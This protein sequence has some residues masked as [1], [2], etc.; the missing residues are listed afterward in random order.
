MLY[1]GID[2]NEFIAEQ[3]APEKRN[4]SPRNLVSDTRRGQWVSEYSGMKRYDSGS[5]VAASYHAIEYYA[6][7]RLYINDQNIFTHYTPECE[8][9]SVS[10]KELKL[11]IKNS[12]AGTNYANKVDDIYNAANKTQTGVINILAKLR[13]EQG[14]GT[15]LTQGI[16]DGNK[17]YYNPYNIC[18]SGNSTKAIIANALAKAKKENWDTFE[19]ALIGGIKLMQTNYTDQNT[20]YLEKFNAT[21][22]NIKSGAGNQYMQNIEDPYSQGIIKR[23]TFLEIDKNLSGRYVFKIPVFKNMPKPRIP[24]P[25]SN[26]TTPNTSGIIKTKPSLPRKA[27]VSIPEGLN[28]R[29]AP[30]LRNN[31]VI[32]TIAP[33]EMIDVIS[34]VKDQGILSWYKIRYNG[35]VGYTTRR[36]E[37][38]PDYFVFMVS[39]VE[40]IKKDLVEKED[41]TKTTYPVTVVFQDDIRIRSAASLSGMHIKWADRGTSGEILGFA[42]S[43]DGYDWYKI[44]NGKSFGYIA[45]NETGSKDFWFLFYEDHMIN[46]NEQQKPEEPEEPEPS[47]E[48]PI[49]T[50][51]IKLIESRMMYG[52]DE[53]I[54]I[55]IDQRVDDLRKINPGVDIKVLDQSEKETNRFMTGGKIKYKDKTHNIVVRGDMN[56]DGQISFLDVLTISSHLNGKITLKNNK[57]TAAFLNL[58]YTNEKVEKEKIGIGVNQMLLLISYMNGYIKYKLD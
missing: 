8:I 16:K 54:Y 12:I 13:Q 56:G 3:Y 40:N 28:F 33:G 22:I 34:F 57:Y 36:G 17:T 7:P 39:S 18:A 51:K 38:E 50:E 32:Q 21:D 2:W 31:G 15:V 29:N 1:T 14:T 11:L 9:G 37:N 41:Q 35:R 5:W 43:K 49:E 55:S 27:R 30:D 46:N 44:K 52:E 6:D 26:T 25:N 58:D 53:T 23:N 4:S 42:G 10:E 48:E 45:R 20:A 47:E 19:K 24:I